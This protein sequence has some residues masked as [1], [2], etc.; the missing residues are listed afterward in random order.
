MYPIIYAVYVLVWAAQQDTARGGITTDKIATAALNGT[1]L[2]LIV[3]AVRIINRR[4]VRNPKRM[5]TLRH[6]ER[7]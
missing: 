5:T 4:G 7:R 6:L 3:P 1:A 2:L